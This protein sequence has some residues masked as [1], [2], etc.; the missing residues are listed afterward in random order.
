MG[1]SYWFECGRCG[2]RAKVSGGADRGLDLY[3]QTILCR[4]CKQLYDAV[5]RIRFPTSARGKTKGKTAGLRPPKLMTQ[6]R[7]LRTPPT[8]LGAL[9]RLPLA[10]ARQFRW[11]RFE[12]QCPV[13]AWHR[14]RNWNE[15]DKC[16]QCGLHLEKNALPYRVWE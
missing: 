8:F 16:P 11:I 9:N 1:R 15:P 12:P 3:V 2:F 4:D 5:I 10:A 14:V 6:P 7:P 13:S